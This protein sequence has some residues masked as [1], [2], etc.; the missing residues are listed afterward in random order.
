MC[1]PSYAAG[2][3]SY[4]ILKVNTDK[5]K[6]NSTDVK[7]DIFKNAYE[8]NKFGCKCKPFPNPTYSTRQIGGL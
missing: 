8:K 6:T 5:E 4:E 3:K 7:I 2:V 1:F